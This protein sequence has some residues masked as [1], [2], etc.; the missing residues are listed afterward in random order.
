MNNVLKEH[1]T[2]IMLNLKHF[3]S[4]EEILGL[5]IERHKNNRW[6]K[7]KKKSYGHNSNWKF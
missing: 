6:S 7:N 4:E 2:I 5:K 1:Q 3:S